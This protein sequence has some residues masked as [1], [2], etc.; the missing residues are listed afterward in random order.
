MNKNEQNHKNITLAVDQ[1]DNAWSTPIKYSKMILNRFCIDEDAAFELSGLYYLNAK[2]Q[3][4]FSDL[5]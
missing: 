3:S 2:S 5:G 1:T 4:Q